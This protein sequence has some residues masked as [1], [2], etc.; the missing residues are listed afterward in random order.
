MH[1]DEQHDWMDGFE[2]WE[3]VWACLRDDW[4]RVADVRQRL[5]LERGPDELMVVEVD[6]GLRARQ[7]RDLHRLGFRPYAAVRTTVW[8]WDVGEAVRTADPA[9]FPHLLLSRYDGVDPAARPRLAE[10]ARTRL[11]T[12][13]LVSR[14]VRRVV[15][16]VFRSTPADVAVVSLRESDVW[17]G[18]DDEDEDDERWQL[19][20]G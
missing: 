8:R 1:I 4:E 15:H 17:D 18:A 10:L 12:E 16:D 13:E 3:D 2:T 11:L 19:P 6:R 20:A 9:D 14:Q 5:E 7:R